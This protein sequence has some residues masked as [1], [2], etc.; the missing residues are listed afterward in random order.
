MG[1]KPIVLINGGGKPISRFYCYKIAQRAIFRAMVLANTHI[2]I[3]DNDLG[4]EL[5]TV[6]KTRKQI[7]ITAP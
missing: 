6:T 4:K 2:Q 3:W 1:K 5:C 7:V